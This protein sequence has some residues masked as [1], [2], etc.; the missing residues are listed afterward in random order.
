MSIIKYDYLHMVGNDI[1]IYFQDDNNLQKLFDSVPRSIWQPYFYVNF[2]HDHFSQGMQ[3]TL[4]DYLR[5]IPDIV[6]SLEN[7]YFLNDD[8]Q[9]RH[10]KAVLDNWRDCVNAIDYFI[11]PNR[12]NV[13][14][15][16]RYADWEEWKYLDCMLRRYFLYFAIQETE[17]I[18]SEILLGY[19]K[20]N[21]LEVD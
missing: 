21:N 7:G 13:D 20:K 3:H 16:Q 6:G 11:M 15:A 2:F 4:F 8:N 1:V 10:K 9:E 14:V 18:W 5:D 17:N 19:I 12:P